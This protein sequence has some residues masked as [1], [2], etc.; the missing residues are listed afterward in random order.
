M[1]AEH[2][3]WPL[4]G[5]VIALAVAL[6]VLNLGTQSL[7]L[8]ELFSRGAALEPTLWGSI[9]HGS[10]KDMFPPLYP[11]ISH[12]AV[13]LPGDAE[14]AMRLPSAVAGI[15]A[16]LVVFGIG[17]LLCS[18]RIGL[19]AAALTSCHWFAVAYSQEGRPYSLLL[20][21]SALATYFGLLV[22]DCERRGRPTR[23]AWLGFGVAG[24]LVCFLHY[25]GALFFGAEALLLLLWAWRDRARLRGL[26][27]SAGAVGVCYAPW[28][29][30]VV[31]QIGHRE[32]TKQPPHLGDV[33]R[34]YSDLLARH[35]WWFAAIIALGSWAATRPVRT[36]TAVP[37]SSVFSARERALL[38]LAWLTMP[39]LITFALSYLVVPIY[40]VRNMI[41]MLPAVALIAALAL[42][43]IERRWLRD[44]PLGA[45]L[46]AAALLFDLIVMKSYYQARKEPAEQLIQQ[47]VAGH[48]ANDELWVEPPRYGRLVAQ[49]LAL[50]GSD[51]QVAEPASR[52]RAEPPAIW[53]LGRNTTPSAPP[54]GYVATQRWEHAPDRRLPW[55]GQPMWLIRYQR[56]GS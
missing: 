38:L 53:V 11:V 20:L 36:P 32:G 46:T 12:F 1:R 33:V 29:S 34:T 47:V 50:A 26:V 16:V 27:L 54:P 40:T 14:A 2:T 44:W 8:D 23:R 56:G 55:A 4:L 49:Y 25:V 41:V 19:V 35:A 18:A 45:T 17:R 6:R 24:L 10:I 9:E 21:F 15:A 30:V 31:V 48:D 7:W 22:V 28:L 13:R 51:V 5:L 52:L 3:L 39:V 42:A 43:Q 37:D